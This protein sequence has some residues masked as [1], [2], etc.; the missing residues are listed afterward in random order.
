MGK[1]TLQHHQV[2]AEVK[3]AWNYT[4]TL[5][6]ISW[7]GAE[8]RTWTTFFLL[9]YATSRKVMGSNPDEVDFFN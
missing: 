9:H 6:Y 2:H 8:L 4:L 5:P 3:N 7:H 1:F